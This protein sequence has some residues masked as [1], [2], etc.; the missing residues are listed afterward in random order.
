MLSSAAIKNILRNTF[1]QINAMIDIALPIP[2]NINAGN[3]NV[4]KYVKLDKP[5]PEMF[6]YVEVF[7]S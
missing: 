4:K 1:S 6:T 3:K 5:W 2:R 7:Q